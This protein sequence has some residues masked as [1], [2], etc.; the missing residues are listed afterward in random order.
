MDANEASAEALIEMRACFGHQDARISIGA[1]ALSVNS[2]T[3]L[4]VG[5]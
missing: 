2:Q 3:N 1:S 4:P 5:R